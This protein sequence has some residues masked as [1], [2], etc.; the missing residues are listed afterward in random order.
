MIGHE[1]CSGKRN[2]R[3]CASPVIVKPCP[4]WRSAFREGFW[5]TLYCNYN[6]D[7]IVLV[8]IK[9]PIVFNFGIG[10]L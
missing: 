5:G 6:E 2:Y 10:K 1:V 9:A 7:K 3:A 4:C 8:I